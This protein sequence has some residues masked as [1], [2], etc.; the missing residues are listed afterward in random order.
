MANGTQDAPAAR[1]WESLSFVQIFRSFGLALDWLKM[2]LALAGIVLTFGFGRLL[3]WAWVRAGN[4]VSANAPWVQLDTHAPTSS[5]THGVF[6]AW[7]SFEGACLDGVLSSARQGVIIG[8]LEAYTVP[9]VGIPANLAEALALAPH[10]GV[11]PNIIDMARGV[12]WVFRYHILHAILFFGGFLLIWSLLGGAI[13]RVSAVQFARNEKLTFGQALGFARS[14]WLNGF[15]LAPLLPLGGL[16]LIALCLW[17]G[18]VVLAIPYLGDILG[19]LLFFLA[20]IG[21]I[22]IALGLIG[23]VAG[24][25]L[26]WPTIAAEGSDSFDAASRSYSYV[27]SRPVRLLFYALVAIIFGAFVFLF[28]AFVAWLSLAVTHAI[29]G[30]GMWRRS[31]DHIWTLGSMNQLHGGSDPNLGY[32][33]KISWF[34]IGL[35]VLL[36]AA[37]VWSFLVSYYFSASTIIYFLLR[38]E[39]DATDLEDVYL[40]K[41]EEEIT[42]APAAP[43]APTAPTGSMPLPVIGGEP[44]SAPS[45]A[46]PSASSEP[47]SPH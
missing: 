29:V 35:W 47:A 14:K 18:G 3:D 12:G 27:Y 34:L 2:G 8:S 22:L 44:V 36:V 26:F 7:R 6:E 37:L 10:V 33:S 17:I 42:P 5:G 46:E 4:G 43:P 11:I 25:S 20:I 45:P 15:F 19:G 13:C 21:G 24:G 1:W 23:L 38:R 39:V 32:P 28:V 9:R 41:L 16:A 30:A 40:D 31:L